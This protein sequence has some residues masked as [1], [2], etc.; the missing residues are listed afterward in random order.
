MDRKIINFE[1]FKKK[2]EEEQKEKEAYLLDD[3]KEKERVVE[4]MSQDK[5]FLIVEIVGDCDVDKDSLL[6]K[7]AFAELNKKPRAEVVDIINKADENIIEMKPA[8]FA[9]AIDIVLGNSD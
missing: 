5:F 3:E 4:N 1:Q 6:Y 7:T 9:A 8:Y 2:K